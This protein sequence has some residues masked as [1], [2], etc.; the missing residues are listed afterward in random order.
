MNHIRARRF[1]YLDLVAV[2][3]N[4]V[5]Q[6][7]VRASQT[8]AV[9]IRNISQAALLLDQLALGSVLRGVRMD[10]HPARTREDR[11]SL[12]QFTR[13]TDRKPRCETIANATT[14]AAVP[15]FEQRD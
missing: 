5:G 1:E 8:E 3:M 11:N 7:H 6:G 14:G 15:L 9:E 10:H 4:A 2:E 13:T 12:E